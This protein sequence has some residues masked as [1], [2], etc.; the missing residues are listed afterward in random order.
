VSVGQREYTAYLIIRRT[1]RCGDSSWLFVLRH[2]YVGANGSAVRRT[3]PRLGCPRRAERLIGASPVDSSYA[4]IYCTLRLSV[5]TDI[6]RIY[7]E[8]FSVNLS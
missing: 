2:A 4:D 8:I 5:I 1:I 6:C 3:D 7:C